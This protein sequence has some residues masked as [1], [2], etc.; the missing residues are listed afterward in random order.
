[1]EGDP[2][3]KRPLET[4]PARAAE[5]VK[6]FR[7]V[8]DRVTHSVEIGVFLLQIVVAM[9]ALRDNSPRLV[10]TEG[11]DVVPRNGCI[12]ILIAEAPRWI[13][14]TGLFVPKYGELHPGAFHQRGEGA[15]HLLVA[16]VVAR[17]SGR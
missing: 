11:L 16:R 2:C 1:M 15:T 17:T 10:P 7:F 8:Q 6:E 9:R 3:S 5:L 13:A 12:E 4:K 14:G